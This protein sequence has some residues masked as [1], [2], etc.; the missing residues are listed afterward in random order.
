MRTVL[1]HYAEPLPRGFVKDAMFYG[2]ITTRTTIRVSFA[3]S[4]CKTHYQTHSGQYCAV[5][6]I[7]S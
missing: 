2:A 1:W 5:N 7:K 3:M 4:Y 6:A